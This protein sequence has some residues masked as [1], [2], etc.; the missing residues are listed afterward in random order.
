MKPKLWT[1]TRT[2]TLDFQP[3]ELWKN[4][5]VLFKLASPWY[6]VMATLGRPIH[7]L[8]QAQVFCFGGVFLVYLFI[9]R[10]S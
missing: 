4:T 7:P 10:D 9:L 6:L 5:F 2:M 3:P 1:L 8:S